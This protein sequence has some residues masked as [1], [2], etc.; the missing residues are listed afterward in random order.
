MG[1]A[2]DE[3]MRLEE[4]QPMYEWIEDNYGDDAGEEG[5]EEWEE[6]VQ[7]FE[8]Y[9]DRQ[10]QKEAEAHLQEELEW[11]IYTQSQIGIFNK[12]IYNIYELLRLELSGETQFSL[13]VMLHGHIVASI[14]SYLASTFIH[15]VTNSE[16]LIRKLVETDPRFSKMKFTLKEIFEKQETLQLIVA[17]YLRSIIFHDLA[18]VKPM[19]KSVLDVDF[20]DISWLFKAVDVRHDCVHRAGFDKDGN[21]VDITRDSIGTL[22]EQSRRLINFIDTKS[23][24]NLF[25]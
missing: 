15:R 14:E 22:I 20:G 18:K 8:A 23:D 12:Q 6:A 5:S 24:K 4:L 21:K 9:C 11:Y 1:Q 16:V 13:F 3:M 17:E 10:Q 19:F 25:P 2:K 7:A